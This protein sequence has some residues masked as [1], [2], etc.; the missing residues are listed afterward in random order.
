LT[1]VIA[2]TELAAPA[3]SI[4]VNLGNLLNA[5][6]T[7]LSLPVKVHLETRSSEANAT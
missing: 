6:G 1:G 2:T 7:A 4:G 5:E 3:S